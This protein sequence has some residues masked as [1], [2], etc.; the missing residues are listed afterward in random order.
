[1]LTSLYSFP[2]S[3]R[4]TCFS[5]KKWLLFTALNLYMGCSLSLECLFTFLCLP[6]LCMS[7]KTPITHCPGLWWHRSSAF[8]LRGCPESSVL[9]LLSHSLFY[10]SPTTNRNSYVPVSVEAGGP[11]H[12]HCGQCPSWDPFFPAKGPMLH[13]PKVW[14]EQLHYPFCL[15]L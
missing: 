7:S 13:A 1:M 9:M 15:L 2:W 3:P 11:C 12:L 14:A 6:E 5:L 4:T 10:C 8:L